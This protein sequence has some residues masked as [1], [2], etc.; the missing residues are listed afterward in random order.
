MSW[1]STLEVY[2]ELQNLIEIVHMQQ[3]FERADAAVCVV[4]CVRVLG[5]RCNVM[6]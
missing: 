2:T 1:K 6:K 3:D 5:Y 4:M